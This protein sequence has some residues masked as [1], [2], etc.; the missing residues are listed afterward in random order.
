[1]TEKDR[2]ELI[3][4]LKSMVEKDSSTLVN[5]LLNITTGLHGFWKK[6]TMANCPLGLLTPI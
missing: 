4:I 6:S 2:F 5:D 3:G 1:L